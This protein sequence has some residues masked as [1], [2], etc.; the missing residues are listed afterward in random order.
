MKWVLLS[1]RGVPGGG[2]SLGGGGR[3]LG[4]ACRGGGVRS[5]GVP[6]GRLPLG[7]ALCFQ[8]LVTVSFSR[9]VFLVLTAQ[10][11]VTFAFVA[12]FTFVKEVQLYVRRNAWTYYLSY[13]IFFCSLITL[14]CCGN[15]RRRHPWNLVALVSE[16]FRGPWVGLV[17]RSNAVS[18]HR[19]S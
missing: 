6:G 5:V 3:S 17:E 13:A 12:V 16:F 2:R 8:C 18:P 4:E 14:S 15:F 10:L 1:W 9:Q 19:L 7:G 11:L